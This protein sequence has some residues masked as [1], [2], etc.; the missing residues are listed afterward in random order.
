VSKCKAFAFLKVKDASALFQNIDGQETQPETITAYKA[1]LYGAIGI[2]VI[3]Y[4]I[5][6]FLFSN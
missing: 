6:F 4:W 5:E 2:K 3:G 1:L